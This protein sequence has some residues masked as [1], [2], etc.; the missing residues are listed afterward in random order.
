MPVFIALVI[1]GCVA[2]WFLLAF[3]YKP[4]G[5]MFYR[6]FKDAAD[7]MAEEENDKK[8]NDE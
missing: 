1:I 5:R 4:V 2:L 8:E 3:L 7:I 6:I